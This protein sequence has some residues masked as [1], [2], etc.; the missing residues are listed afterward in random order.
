VRAK[1]TTDIGKLKPS[2]ERKSTFSEAP[3]PNLKMKDLLSEMVIIGFYH[4]C[5]AVETIAS[6]SF[7]HWG[8]ATWTRKGEFINA[9]EAVAMTQPLSKK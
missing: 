8:G 3:V 5:D 6:P 2:Q 7:C 1:H 9:I 4:K